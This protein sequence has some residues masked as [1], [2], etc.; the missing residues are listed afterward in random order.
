V[1][2]YQSLIT[3]VIGHNCNQEVCQKD[4]F[5][6]LRRGKV[7]ETLYPQSFKKEA[8]YHRDIRGKNKPSQYEKVFQNEVADYW[9]LYSSIFR[10]NVEIPIF[11]SRAVSDLLC[12]V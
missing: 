4:A 5:L 6:L 8:I 1:M 11:N 2:R 10:Y 9:I 7:A 12:F 3:V